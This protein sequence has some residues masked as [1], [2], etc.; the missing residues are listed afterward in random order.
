M[1]KRCLENIILFSGVDYRKQRVKEI[2]QGLEKSFTG[3][4][5]NVM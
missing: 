5:E 1:S 2:C 4:C 3:E